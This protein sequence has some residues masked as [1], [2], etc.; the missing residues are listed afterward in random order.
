M[1]YNA[2]KLFMDVNPNLFDD[3]SHDYS[4][5]QSSLPAREAERQHKWAVVTEHA[6]RCRIER[7]LPPGPALPP[8]PSSIRP[9]AGLSG[10]LSHHQHLLPRLDEDGAGDE[11]DGHMVG[12][13]ALNLGDEHGER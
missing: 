9:P 8:I 12:M 1:V 5:L 11:G 10:A 3:C 7:G 13:G 4:E 2:M 6:E